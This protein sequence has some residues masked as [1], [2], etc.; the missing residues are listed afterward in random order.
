MAKPTYKPGDAV[1]VVL[2]DRSLAPA[3]ITRV[4]GDGTADLKFEHHDQVVVITSSPLDEAGKRPDSWR[5]V[6]P[7]APSAEPEA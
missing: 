7:P 1:Q 4:N 2:A 5:P 6:A 3:K